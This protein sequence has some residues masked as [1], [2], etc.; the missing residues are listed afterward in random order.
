M[1]LTVLR[2]IFF[3]NILCN[4]VCVANEVKEILELTLWGVL[5]IEGNSILWTPKLYSPNIH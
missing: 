3:E 4:K 5:F 2:L 1:N